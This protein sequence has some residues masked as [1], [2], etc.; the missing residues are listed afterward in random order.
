MSGQG[1]DW[2]S[3]ETA[4]RQIGGVTPRWIRMQIEA[5]RL[6]ARV[7]LTGRRV[8]YR[9]RRDDLDEFLAA[10]VVDD[11]RDINGSRLPD[12]RGR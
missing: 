10:F 9:I 1:D 2:L 7:L 11:A 8:T 12:A 3:S 6:R 5:G 4:S